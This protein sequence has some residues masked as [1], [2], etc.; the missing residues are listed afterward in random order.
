METWEQNPSSWWRGKPSISQT[1][2]SP[3]RSMFLRKKNP[4]HIFFFTYSSLSNRFMWWNVGYHCLTIL[5]LLPNCLSQAMCGQE[6]VL[7]HTSQIM[8]NVRLP[9]EHMYVASQHCF[10]FL[11]NELFPTI[12]F[13]QKEFIIEYMNSV[14]T[15]QSECTEELSQIVEWAVCGLF[16]L[17]Y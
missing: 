10:T 15:F 14:V 5:N 4:N 3:L 6:G 1:E 8:L 11:K 16:N 9:R 13:L 17:F 2:Y 7:N 12:S